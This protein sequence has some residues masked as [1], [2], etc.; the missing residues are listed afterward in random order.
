[1]NNATGSGQSAADVVNRA[2]PALI[3][4]STVS[5]LVFS[6]VFSVIGS[7]AEMMSL[8]AAHSGDTELEKSLDSTAF[9]MMSLSSAEIDT[10]FPFREAAAVMQRLAEVALKR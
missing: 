5:S 6:Q 8:M 7:S 1:M 10:P 3:K 9:Q 4:D 2:E